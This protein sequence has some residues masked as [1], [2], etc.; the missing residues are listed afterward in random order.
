MIF[1]QIARRTIKL[2]KCKK[3]SMPHISSKVFDEAI[4]YA[5]FLFN[6]LGG[7]LSWKIVGVLEDIV[8]H[9]SVL[10]P[11][12]SYLFLQTLHNIF[13]RFFSLSII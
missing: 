5:R 10:S 6:V 11:G 1:S 9:K 2:F 3:L 13:L 7:M 12:K 8:Q 4:S